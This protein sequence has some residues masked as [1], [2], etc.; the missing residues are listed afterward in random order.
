MAYEP[1]ARPSL[2]HLADKFNTAA[3]P[4]YVSGRGRGISG[5]SQPPPEPPARGKKRGGAPVAGASSSRGAYGEEADRFMYDDDDTQGEGAGSSAISS[6][7][8]ENTFGADGKLQGEAGDTQF[9][10]RD[11][12]EKY[13]VE[14]TSMSQAEAGW[15]IEPFSMKEERA[16]GHFDEEGGYVCKH[17]R[18]GATG[19]RQHGE[20]ARRTHGHR[21]TGP[22]RHGRARPPRKS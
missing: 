14:R 3:P 10:L 17:R 5:F 8:N 12:T 13:E 15:A 21:R 16:E 18:E 6:G 9:D 11:G 7:R 4:G 1:K 22:R 2:G 20:V 19:A